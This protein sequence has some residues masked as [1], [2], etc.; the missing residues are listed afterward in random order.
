MVLLG[1]DVKA[2]PKSKLSLRN[3]YISQV[4]SIHFLALA[5]F[6]KGLVLE[7]KL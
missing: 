4:D 7:H 5:F 2:G 6:S 3:N 1:A